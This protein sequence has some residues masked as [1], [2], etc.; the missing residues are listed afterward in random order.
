MIPVATTAINIVQRLGGPIAT[1]LLATFLHAELAASVPSGA[2][3]SG[4]VSI[5]NRAFLNAPGW[6]AHAFSA[7]FW[8]LCAF[9]AASILASLRLPLWARRH[10]A[11]ISGES[12]QAIEAI[13]E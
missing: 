3:V 1:T 10:P 9:H 4:S 12:E 2:S 6:N 11:S 8:L 5:V 7:T 13:T